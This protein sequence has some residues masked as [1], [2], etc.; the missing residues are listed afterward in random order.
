MATQSARTGSLES[1]A[2]W[3]RPDLPLCL[4]SKASLTQVQYQMGE[5]PSKARQTLCLADTSRTAFVVRMF[6]A[7]IG[8]AQPLEASTREAAKV[9]VW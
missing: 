2:D 7:C 8:R 4:S 6:W 5:I 3:P 1:L 9:V